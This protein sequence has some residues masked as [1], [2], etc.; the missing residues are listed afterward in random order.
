MK[1]IFL[2]YCCESLNLSC[3]LAFPKKRLFCFFLYYQN[4]TLSP[5]SVGSLQNDLCVTEAFAMIELSWL[6]LSVASLVQSVQ[7]SLWGPGEIVV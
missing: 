3:V 1:A 7:E 2:L 5:G 6:I 4:E